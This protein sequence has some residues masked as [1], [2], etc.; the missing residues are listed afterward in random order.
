MIYICVAF[1]EEAK[2]LLSQWQFKQD[3]HAPC[4]LYVS[5]EIY[6]VITQMG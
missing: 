3:K 4:K 5:D 2:P 6:L 1:K